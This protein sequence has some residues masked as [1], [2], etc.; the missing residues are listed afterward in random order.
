MR[1]PILKAVAMPPKFL[2]APFLP[3]LANLGVQFPMMFII[4]GFVDYNPFLFVISIVIVHAFLVAYGAKEPHLSTLLA[5]YGLFAGGSK[6]V[7]KSKGTKL[8]P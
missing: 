1:E 6:N 2:W 7:Y 4:M 8:A 5:S 3:A